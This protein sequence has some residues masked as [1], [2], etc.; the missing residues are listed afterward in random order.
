MFDSSGC[1]G[2]VEG[3]YA[4]A[5]PM[6]PVIDLDGIDQ[7]GVNC[8]RPI[9]GWRSARE[10]KLKGFVE[11]VHAAYQDICELD[12]PFFL[13][14][15]SRLRDKLYC[16]GL[17]EDE[18]KAQAFAIIQHVAYKTLNMRHHDVQLMGGFVMLSGL[19]AEM[20]TGEGK[21]L[22]ATLPACAAALSGIP[23][24][25]ITVNDYL[26]KRDAE[27]MEPVYNY[28]GLRVGV[29]QEGMSPP[30]RQA[31]YDCDITYCS[32]KEVAFDYLK[33]KI[34]LD[35]KQGRT[36]LQVD[37]FSR[38]RQRQLILR[39]LQFAIVD[40]ADSVLID[41]AK[42][43]LV[44]SAGGDSSD[45]C[46]LYQQ[47]LS[48]A[49]ELIENKDY[50][51]NLRHRSIYIK[52]KGKETIS[53]LSS[54]LGGIW[55][56][57]K[58]RESLIQQA[59][60]ALYIQ[61][62]DE[63]YIIQDGKIQIVDENTGRVMDDR[64]WEAGLH[65]MIEVKEG[66]ELTGERETLAQTSYQRFFSQ[67]LNLCGMTGTAKEVRSELW[68]YYR[69]NIKSIP[70]HKPCL[71]EVL[72]PQVCVSKEQKWKYLIQRIKRLYQLQSPLLIGVASVKESE[73]LHEILLAENIEHRVINAR[74]A[75]F[76]AEIIAQAGQIGQVTIATNMAGRG[77]D[78]KL[79][80]NAKAA[81]GLHVI[82]TEHHES[83]RIDR[84]L[85]GR[86]ARQGDP[87]SYEFILSLED[88]ILRQFIPANLLQLFKRIAKLNPYF[89][90][91]FGVKLLRISQRRAEKQHAVMRRQLFESDKRQDEMMRFNGNV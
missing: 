20:Q 15:V 56:G 91:G 65:Q 8:Y 35:G 54:S 57:K 48:V 81:G 82:L 49:G 71:R 78:I 80:K 77:T 37:K 26:A 10:G 72:P 51:F 33:D 84:Q 87:G 22:T 23:V 50:E 53:E 75:E 69:L 88:D 4:G 73:I 86:C 66:C 61:N 47:A 70:V 58:R 1:R 43:P 85:I 28:L 34:A 74:E 89:L 14:S 60:S 9:A 16:E 32:N 62:K 7:W 79:A 36:R 68:S 2:K 17:G 5:Y 41:E 19:I 55:R 42:T 39:G 40:E 45:E 12:E 30:E 38:N 63:N 3:C 67:Y 46:L 64:S 11:M 18:N 90:S 52:E 21:T 76:E 13:Q 24:H 29:I 59:L 25:V 27:E 83:K 6:R 31:I 44:I